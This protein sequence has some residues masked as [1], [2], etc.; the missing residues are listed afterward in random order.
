MKDNLNNGV[1]VLNKAKEVFLRNRYLKLC[2][3]LLGCMVL[4]LFVFY[5]AISLWDKKNSFSV[6]VSSYG[7]ENI[8]KE[9]NTGSIML[10]SNPDFTTPSTHIDCSGISGLNNISVLDI[11]LDVDSIDGEHSGDDY[12]ALTFYVK[13]VGIGSFISDKVLINNCYRHVDEAIRVGIY[14]NGEYLQYAKL[15]S[16]GDCEYNCVGFFSD[17]IVSFNEYYLNENEVVKYTIVIWLEG[18][19]PDCTDDLFGGHINLSME[20]CVVNSE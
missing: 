10:S 7:L 6:M 1:S 20:F 18:D 14:R 11:P 8:N 2:S 9:L 15:N 19:D 5:L 16:E 12:I 13:N 17:D 3:I 4:V